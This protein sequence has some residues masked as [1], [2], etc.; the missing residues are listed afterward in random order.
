MLL[1]QSKCSGN[2]IESNFEILL[3]QMMFW[4]S[5][6]LENI[7][8]ESPKPPSSIDQLLHANNFQSN[9]QMFSNKLSNVFPNDSVS[10][11]VRKP[12]SRR[13]YPPK[14]PY[15]LIVQLFDAFSDSLDWMLCA[16]HP[17][18]RIP[19]LTEWKLSCWV[20]NPAKQQQ[21]EIVRKPLGGR[22]L[23]V[24]KSSFTNCG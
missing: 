9:E 4:W 16:I 17:S 3:T 8:Q 2:T 24:L 5:S 13:F 1:Q 21:S 19:L 6:D 18:R 23:N 10:F 11:I 15:I 7:S 12:W 14:R 20:F 22:A